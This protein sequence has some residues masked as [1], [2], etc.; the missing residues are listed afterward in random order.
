VDRL[1]STEDQNDH[2][3]IVHLSSNTFR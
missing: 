1:T 3:P 2:R